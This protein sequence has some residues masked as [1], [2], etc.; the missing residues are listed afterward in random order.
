MRIVDKATFL[1]LPGPV[2]FKE[3]REPWV[4]EDLQVRNWVSLEHKDFTAAQ[5]DWPKSPQ[6]HDGYA[7]MGAHPGISIP[8][9]LATIRDGSFNDEAKY[10]IYEPADVQVIIDLLTKC[11]R[12]GT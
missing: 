4:F 12:P 3:L 6:C 9:E 5:L 1:A 2:L 8:L 11:R 7:I 10:M